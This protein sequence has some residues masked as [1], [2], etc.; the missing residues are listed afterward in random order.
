M[1][2]IDH[3]DIESTNILFIIGFLISFFSLKSCSNQGCI[4]SVVFILMTIIITGI[5][6]FLTI[7][8]TKN[9]E[10]NKLR[11]L[12]ITPTF[13]LLTLFVILLIISLF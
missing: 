1:W 5:L 12:W 4:L 8:R 9:Q 10:R 2:L 13:I 7:I 6:I 3:W 11:L